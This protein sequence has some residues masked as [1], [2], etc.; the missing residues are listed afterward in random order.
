MT[1]V[2]FVK[3]ARTKQSAMITDEGRRTK[4]KGRTA[5][6]KPVVFRLSSCVIRCKKIGIDAELRQHA[7]RPA[8]AVVPH[9]LGRLLDASDRV[10]GVAKGVLLEPAE[11]W[12]VAPINSGPV[13]KAAARAIAYARAHGLVG[14]EVER[15][16]I[17]MEYIGP[18]VCE[19]PVDRW[20]EMHMMPA[21]QPDRQHRQP[22]AA[23]KTPFQY[24][25]AHTRLAPN[26]RH[27]NRQLDAGQ[28]RQLF[29]F[30]L[31]GTNNQRLGEHEYSHRN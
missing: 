16:F 15:L 17:N 6:V 4:D 13:V 14:G 25:I 24:L 29:G 10:G 3:K 11:R 5:L 18:N 27:R 7:D 30:L 28:R 2:C 31:I 8:V 9:D 26:R 22:V 21:I 12:R 19:Q 20:V 23:H 1:S